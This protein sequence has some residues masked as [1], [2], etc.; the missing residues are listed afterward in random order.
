MGYWGQP[1]QALLVWIKLIRLR[2]VSKKKE[3]SFWISSFLGLVQ[4]SMVHIF[5]EIQL[6][7]LLLQDTGYSLNF[8]VPLSL[9]VLFPYIA[10]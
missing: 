8:S 6:Q 7:G 2:E 9:G 4:G 1:I 3:E 5:P 10:I